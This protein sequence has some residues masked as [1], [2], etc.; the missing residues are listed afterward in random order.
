M[1]DMPATRSGVVVSDV[2]H[3]RNEVRRGIGGANGFWDVKL[4][5]T[6]P[7]S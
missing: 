1:S 7:A 6:P 4:F 2:G 5:L 3:A